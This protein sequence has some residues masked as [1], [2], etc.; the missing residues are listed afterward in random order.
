MKSPSS[1][2]YRQHGLHGPYGQTTVSAPFPSTP[3]IK[4]DNA[5]NTQERANTQVRP[6]GKY[7][8]AIHH[9]RSIRLQGYDYSQAGA[10]F[11][12]VCTQNRECLF[13]DDAV[14]LVNGSGDV[15]ISSREPAFAAWLPAA[16]PPPKIPAATAMAGFTSPTAPAA[17]M[18][19]AGIRMMG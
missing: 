3:S 4:N 9:R 11:V 5:T 16:R 14:Q 7:D 6:Y 13:G 2:I 18:A 1:A 8:P 12:T 15:F 19:P 10:Y 17:S